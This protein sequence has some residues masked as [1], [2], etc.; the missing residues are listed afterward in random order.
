MR[1]GEVAYFPDPDHPVDPL[2]VVLTATGT[3]QARAAGAA[4][5]D[6]VF[7][8]VVTSGLPRTIR[9]AEL[10]VAELSTPPRTA[11]AHD[12]DLQELHAG[13]LD[14]ISDDDLEE[15]FLGAW[16]GRATRDVR[17]LGG[18]TV[19]ELVDRVGAAIDRLLGDTDW[20]TI[21]LVAHGGVNRAILSAALNGPGSFFGQ[22]EQ[23]PGCINIIDVEPG[24]VLRAVNHLPYD[25]LHSCG[26]RITTLEDMLQQCRRARA[27]S[28]GGGRPFA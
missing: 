25:P 6:V 12:H 27:Q 18:E 15:A 26:E 13:D 21:L 17:F 24:Y 11:I 8:R 16:R 14:L 3:E 23:S 7:D 1:H 19:G 9:T 20:D 5:A 28:R 4:L 2:D 10:V 22:L